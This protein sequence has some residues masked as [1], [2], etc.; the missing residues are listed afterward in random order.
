MT[1]YEMVNNTIDVYV[2]LQRIKKAETGENKEL[3]YLISVYEIKL[4]N[5]GV[6]VD[7]LKL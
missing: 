1:Q 5:F 6:S 4:A 7:S 3:D 2:M